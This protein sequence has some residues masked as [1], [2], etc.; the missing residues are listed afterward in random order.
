[1]TQFALP[2]TVIYN[3]RMKSLPR[4]LEE[5]KS[6]CEKS[7]SYRELLSNLDYAVSG[8][9]LRTVKKM[10]DVYGLS[11]KHKRKQGRKMEFSEI[12]V[13]NS[14]YNHTKYLKN[15]LL[16][17]GILVN[18]CV[19]CGNNGTWLNKPITLQLDHINGNSS[20]NRVENLRLLCPNCHTQTETWGSKRRP[21]GESNPGFHRDRMAV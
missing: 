6:A 18:V 12:L 7:S 16:K 15:R 11:I 14:P 8:G 20:D 19:L 4:T 1:M 3:F 2:K 9:N 21:D 13:Q 17:E 10:L 5:V